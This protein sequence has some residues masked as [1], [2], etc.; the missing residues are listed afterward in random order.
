M[1]GFLGKWKMTDAE[2]LEPLCT[3]LG[4]TTPVAQVEAILN[5]DMIIERD[6]DKYYIHNHAAVVDFGLKFKLGEAWDNTTLS[7]KVVRTEITLE[8]NTL[9]WY[10]HRE[11]PL[12]VLFVLEGNKI[13][14]VSDVF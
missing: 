3:R 9:K 8:G 5:T 7:G 6:G 4:V 11:K 10:E 14:L 2:G 13:T 1:E 12:T